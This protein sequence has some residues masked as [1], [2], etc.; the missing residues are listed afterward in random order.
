MT[1][2]WAL[3]PAGLINSPGFVNPRDIEQIINQADQVA[4]LSLDDR[5]CPL[6]LGLPG[7]MRAQDLGGI[8]DRRKRI[9]QRQGRQGTPVHEV[10][11]LCNLYQS[12]MIVGLAKNKGID[13]NAARQE[14]MNMIGGIPMGRP[15]HPEEIAELAAF[16]ASARAASIHGA[17]YVID[18]GT[19]PTT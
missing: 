18:G 14:I 17:D 1:G 13:E 2:N 5:T 4:C 15:A 6:Q 12:S 7:G 11:S 16:L 8:A 10:D 19:M 9:A 3:P